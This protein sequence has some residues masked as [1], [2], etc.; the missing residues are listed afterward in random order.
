MPEL[1]PDC[2]A[3]VSKRNGLFVAD[4]KSLA[5]RSL[6]AEHV[7]HSQ[8]MSIGNIANIGEVVEI[9]T[10]PDGKGRFELSN[11]SVDCGNQMIVSRAQNN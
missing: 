10:I 11:T 6:R 9:Q 1:F 2:F 7:F 3:K 4:E 5:C 8:D